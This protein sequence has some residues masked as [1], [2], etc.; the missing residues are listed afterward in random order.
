MMVKKIIS[1]GQTGVD[2]A[3]LDVAIDLGIPHGGWIPKGRKTE[4]GTL[5]AKYQLREMPTSSYPKRTEQNVI[6]SDG[7]LIISHGRLTGGSL[8]TFKMA[9]QHRRPCLHIDLS[10]GTAFED[11]MKIN[12][13]IEANQV[14][15]LNVAGP[16]ASKDPEI[17]EA[18]KVLLQTACHM[19]IIS[20]EMPDPNLVAPF[21]PQTVDEAVE[22]LISEIPLKDRIEMAKMEGPELVT[23]QPT[24]GRYIKNKYELWAENG[25][26]MLSCRLRSGIA[27]L[28][29]DG[30]AAL[31]IIELWKKL[32]ETHSLRVVG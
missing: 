24:L 23:L 1:G 5:P 8:F 18:A 13:W 32:R 22:R 21:L 26:L 31:I 20:K 7:T 3:A 14:E 11:A 10:K 9:K 15:V 28:H 25:K 16:R 12:T 6:D 19:N 29:E 4:D 30:A 27:D 2:Q 17:Y